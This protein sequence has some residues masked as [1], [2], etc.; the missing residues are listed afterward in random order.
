MELLTIQKQFKKAV[1]KNPSA[2]KAN[3]YFI[4]FFQFYEKN[5]PLVFADPVAIGNLK[6]NSK[7]INPTFIYPFY[8]DMLPKLKLEEL[9][10][11]DIENLLLY[12]YDHHDSS[13]YD[14]YEG[15]A[16]KEYID[17]EKGE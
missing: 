16:S 15:L 11:T 1:L 6:Y 12:L 9:T 8:C 2:A 14:D 7:L 4:V 5:S 13:C 3:F 17:Y 10:P